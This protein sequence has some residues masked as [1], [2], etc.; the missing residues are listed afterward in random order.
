MAEAKVRFGDQTTVR[1]QAAL[2]KIEQDTPDRLVLRA[3]KIGAIGGGIFL[4]VFGLILGWGTH[5]LNNKRTYGAAV[6]AGV[7]GLLLLAGGVALLRLG[8]RNQDRIVFDRSARE[9]RFE[10]TKEKDRYTIPF[11]D[12]EKFKLRFEDKSFSSK[13]IQVVFRFVIM[14]KSGDE[15]KVDEAFKLDEMK[16]LAAKASQLCGVPFDESAG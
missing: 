16:G 9:V 5:A 11:S 2:Y 15:I 13:D 6:I 7:I 10:M 12:I 8:I 4:T 1:R 14:T 3:K